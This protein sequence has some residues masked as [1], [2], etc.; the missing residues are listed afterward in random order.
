MNAAG[1][2]RVGGR[3]MSRTAHSIAKE[4]T[5]VEDQ[6]LPTFLTAHQIADAFQVSRHR[7][8]DLARKGIIPS[9]RIGRQLRFSSDDVGQWVRAGGSGLGSHDAA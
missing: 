8:Y 6:L 9:V 7:V 1:T 3:A 4:S 2:L 5:E